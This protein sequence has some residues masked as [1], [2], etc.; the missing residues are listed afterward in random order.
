M[1][2]W[3]DRAPGTLDTDLTDEK[4][5]QMRPELA[6]KSKARME[7]EAKAMAAKVKADKAG[8]VKASVTTL[9]TDHTDEVAWNERKVLAQ[10]SRDRRAARQAEIDEQNRKYREMVRRTKSSDKIDDD[11]R[12]AHLTGHAFALANETRSRPIRPPSSGPLH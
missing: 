5:W 3:N 9:D 1:S 11:L 8:V 10:K 7:K 2:W 6:A 4:A 12:G